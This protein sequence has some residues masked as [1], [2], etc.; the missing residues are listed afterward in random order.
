MLKNRKSKIENRKLSR[1]FTL[2]EL[3]IV[4]GILGIIAAVVFVALDPGT[5]FADARDSRRWTDISAVI[6]A[7]K[8]YQV[9]YEGSLPTDVAAL[10][11][12]TNYIIGTAALGC[13]SG[14]ADV[15]PTA[16]ACA[17]LEATATTNI[18]D[19]GY[20]GKI[21]ISPT[22]AGGT[23]YDA[24]KTGYTISRDANNIITVSACDSEGA[25]VADISVVR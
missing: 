1:G 9:D 21:P 23:A 15:T 5:R 24:T 3:L 7:V 17:N 8:V 16:A 4:I 10:T 20:I 19:G 2:I 6:D 18:I 25:G 14:C 11:A 12:G 13:D 22:P